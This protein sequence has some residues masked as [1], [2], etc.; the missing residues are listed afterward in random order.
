[1]ADILL[2]PNISFDEK[3]VGPRPVTAIAGNRIGV[4]GEFMKGPNNQFTLVASQDDLIKLFG[5]DIRNGSLA[6][7]TAMDQG[8]LDFGIRRVMGTG[9]PAGGHL[10]LNLSGTAGSSGKVV[11]FATS[12]IVPVLGNG[13]TSKEEVAR[14]IADGVQGTN[15]AGLSATVQGNVVNMQ[16]VFDGLP[17]M[18][19]FVD[20]ANPAGTLNNPGLLLRNS[21]GQIIAPDTV[22]RMAGSALEVKVDYDESAIQGVL[23]VNG[24]GSAD[25]DDLVV[26][27]G[28]ETRTVARNATSLAKLSVGTALANNET[29]RVTIGSVTKEVKKDNNQ[30]SAALMASLEA[31]FAAANPD[32]LNYLNV[33]DGSG[34]DAGK[35]LVSS[36]ANVPF[37][38][39]ET[40][41]NLSVLVLPASEGAAVTGV[42]SWDNSGKVEPVVTSAAGF[43]ANLASKFQNLPGLVVTASNA[44][45]TVKPASGI[46]L[47]NEVK[48]STLGDVSASWSTDYLRPVQGVADSVHL[49]IMVG[50][51]ADVAQGTSTAASIAEALATSING[52]GLPLAVQIDSNGQ[53]LQLTSRF[54]GLDGNKALICLAQY[55]NNIL[56]VVGYGTA[57]VLSAQYRP[58]VPGVNFT[59]LSNSSA[60]KLGG[61]AVSPSKGEATF[62]RRKFVRAVAV[63]TLAAGS[64]A[65]NGKAIL[66]LTS[67]E[68]ALN[69]NHK[70]DLSGLT[71]VMNV[72]A[73]VNNVA[74]SLVVARLNSG[75]LE[76][77]TVENASDTNNEVVI[78]R[79]TLT[80][81]Y[82][83]NTNL[84]TF[85]TQDEGKAVNGDIIRVVAASEGKWSENLAVTVQPAQNQGILIT[86]TYGNPTDENYVAETYE[87]RLGLD[88]TLDS[89]VPYP[90]VVETANSSLIRV[91]YVGGTPEGKVAQ[92]YGQTL[93]LVGGADGPPASPEDYIRV[94]NS[95]GLD[96]VNIIIAS[97]NTHPRVRSA[98]VAQ[99]EAA[100][101]VSGLRIAVLAADR[102]LSASRA[103][104]LTQ[105]LDSAYAV[106]VGGWATYTGRDGLAPLSTPP[107]GFYAGHLAATSRI[108]VS[109]AARSSSPKFEKIKEVDIPSPGSQSYNAYTAARIEMIILDQATGVFHC[110]NGRS[111]STD[112][113]WQWISLRRVYN[114]IRANVFQNLQFAKSE[115]NNPELRSRVAN[116]IDQFLFIMQTKQEISGYQPTKVDS[117]NN[118]TNLVAQGMMRVD[119]FFSPVYPADFI[120]VGL[121]RVIPVSLTVQTGQ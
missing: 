16:S 36:K 49:H 119:V 77:A 29:L 55:V 2:F 102:R 111:L 104:N 37:T 38:G 32:F 106:M 8:A 72:G 10:K 94:I 101:E 52:T 46:S 79:Y 78:G 84:G 105:G 14:R 35:L 50:A 83:S 13:T 80:G 112:K 121:H 87:V 89:A 23:T 51:E 68:I 19:R 11:L 1:M 117:E 100:D 30:T 110:L 18:F 65:N 40:A 118:P 3:D 86:A 103:A 9:I 93:K 75:I 17:I 82:N 95:M 90:L 21:N 41:V 88:G 113:A 64:G 33:E 98:L 56:A 28:S 43:A 96:P 48:L 58:N 61:A 60:V 92:V 66:T 57:G 108:E 76:L 115:P 54:N 85:N 109:P 67:G 63:G 45:L 62:R 44:T 114:Y 99:A 59:D 70:L 107:D 7:Q 24:A 22:V 53:V 97:G 74:S 120:T 69:N 20:P 26:Q 4:V 39:G 47:V 116:V 73:A 71:C 42:A 12:G 15:V 31:A 25:G 6:V 91:T 81:A 27:I 34:N 5:K